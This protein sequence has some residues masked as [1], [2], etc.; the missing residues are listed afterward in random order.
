MEKINGAINNSNK[1]TTNI[2]KFIVE[3]KE[4]SNELEVVESLNTYFADIGLNLA[5]HFTLDA[6]RDLFPSICYKSLFL[7]PASDFEI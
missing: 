7:S 1:N 4:V 6:G 2:N 3:V 5:N